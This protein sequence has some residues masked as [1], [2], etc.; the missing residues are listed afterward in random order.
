M[1]LR[2]D[3]AALRTEREAKRNPDWVRIM[4]RA[5]DDLRDS[6]IARRVVKPGARAPE[7]DLL[8]TQGERRTSREL[9]ARGPLVVNFYRGVW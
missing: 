2:E 1:G 3:L 6:G 5:T 7:F 9:L 8:N 4:H